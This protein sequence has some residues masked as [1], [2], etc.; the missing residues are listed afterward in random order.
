M[1]PSRLLCTPSLICHSVSVN[2]D[3]AAEDHQLSN[4][5]GSVVCTFRVPDVVASYFETGI[6]VHNHFLNQSVSSSREVFFCVVKCVWR[7]LGKNTN[8]KPAEFSLLKLCGLNGYFKR[9]MKPDRSFSSRKWTLIE[10]C[11]R[12]PP[13]SIQYSGRQIPLNQ[14]GKRY[15]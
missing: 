6:C 2:I 12:P 1:A 9:A 15:L 4:A 7:F 14:K 3:T 13:W 11:S 8:T 5:Y 10:E